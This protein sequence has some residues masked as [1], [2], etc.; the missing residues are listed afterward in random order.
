MDYHTNDAGLFLPL[1][2]P[3]D[4]DPN[5]FTFDPAILEEVS[6]HLYAINNYFNTI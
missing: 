1:A 3:P 6:H 4:F 2:E 5:E